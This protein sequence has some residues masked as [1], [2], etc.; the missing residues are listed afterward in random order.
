MIAK[1]EVD[2]G[3]KEGERLLRLMDALD[4]QDDVQQVYSNG[5]LAEDVLANAL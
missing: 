2:V 1:N 3:G 4:D 5:N